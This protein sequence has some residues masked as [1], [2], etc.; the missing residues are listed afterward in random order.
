MFLTKV[1]GDVVVREFAFKAG[2]HGFENPSEA[3]ADSDS[4]YGGRLELLR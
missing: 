1:L 3:G 2:R 4:S